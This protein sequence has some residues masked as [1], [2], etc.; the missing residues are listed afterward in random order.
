[1][2]AATRRLTGRISVALPATQAFELFTP[3]GERT[4]AHGWDPHF[5]V[6]VTDDSRPGTVFETQPHRH[7]HATTW[8]VTQRSQGVSIGYARVTPGDRAGTVTVVLEAVSEDE[9][10][11]EVSYDLT[12]LS[13]SAQAALDDFAAGYDDYLQSWQQAINASVVGRPAT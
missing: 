4:W 11:V 1:M 6:P 12:P 7:G 8:V 9:T 10:E 5:P 13:P 3:D 2:R